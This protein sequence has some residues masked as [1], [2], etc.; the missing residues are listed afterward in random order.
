[1]QKEVHVAQVA[2]S[3]MA[4]TVLLH[5]HVRALEQSGYR[6]TAI[7]APGPWAEQARQKGI[8]VETVDFRRELSPASDLRAF[9]QLHSLFR[10]RRF[11]IVHTHT[12][13]AGL[14]GPLAAQLAGVPT[15]LHTVHGFLFHDRMP[16]WKRSLFWASEKFTATFADQ[17]LSQ[18]EEDVDVARTTHLCSAS[19]V[20][21]LGNGIDVDFFRPSRAKEVRASAR[22]ELGVSD[23][24]IVVGS[25]GRFVYE[26]GFAELFCAANQIITKH[27]HIHFLM[28]GGR[29]HDQSDCV[30]AETFERLRPTKRFHILD[31]QNDMLKWYSAMDLF[32]LPSHREGVP[33]ACMEASAM[34]LPV[35]AT[36]IR[37]CREVIID[38]ES[39]ILVPV[40]DAQ[41]LAGAIE[42]LVA[43]SDVR[44]NM[45]A[46]GR[47]HIV[48]N[49]SQ[50]QVLDRLLRLYSQVAPLNREVM[51]TYA[52]C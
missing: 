46:Y 49:F 47:Q 3:G 2:T 15:V 35:V 27:A 23:S 32:V 17:L 50:R 20:H 4:I 51:A 37:G 25:V 8:H 41:R 28:I 10:R 33:R 29:D 5:D 31:W 24:E 52:G 38:R 39:G 40:R 6:V 43:E 34:E 12:P 9:W 19:R 45:G 13:K 18:S 22:A 7:C 26:K 16:L 30:E 14:L 36:D 42:S 1:M 48:A 11:Q 21:Y 44:H